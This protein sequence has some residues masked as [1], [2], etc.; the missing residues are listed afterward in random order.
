MVEGYGDSPAAATFRT[1]LIA[2][3]RKRKTHHYLITYPVRQ[4]MRQQ[5]FSALRADAGAML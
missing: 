1:G 3:T 2:A 4:V 5:V